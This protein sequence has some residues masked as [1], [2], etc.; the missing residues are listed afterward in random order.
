MAAALT[1]AASLIGI[2]SSVT[3]FGWFTPLAFYA[4]LILV[5]LAILVISAGFASILLG[6]VGVAPI[7]LIFNHA[8]ALVLLVMQE[9]LAWGLGGAASRPAEFV[10]SYWGQLGMALVLATMV[11]VR[12]RTQPGNRWRWWGPPLVTVLVLVFGLRLA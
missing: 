11:I 12:E 4:N 1:W 2:L 9:A 6:L 3:F 5:P 8:A 10:T 7:A